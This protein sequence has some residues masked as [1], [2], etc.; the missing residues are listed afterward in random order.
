MTTVL[1]DNVF[2][3]AVKG[4]F[5]DC[6]DM[7]KQSFADQS[8]LLGRRRLVAVN[9][10]NW[11][12]VMAQ[13]VYY[14][15]SA[16]SLGCVDRNIAF[17]VPTGN[18]GDIYA[19]YLAKKMGLPISQ[20][21][22]ATNKNDIL[23]R[24]LNNNDY[25]KQ[26]LEHTLSPSMDIMVSSNFERLLFD[27]HDQDGAAIRDLMADFDANASFSI[28]TERWQRA[29]QLFSSACID[30]AA[31]CDSI[32]NNFRSNEEILDPHTAIGVAA[33]K[34]CKRD[35]EVPMVTLATAHPAKFPEAIKKAGID[36]ELDLPPHMADLM[37]KQERYEIMEH[38]IN[39]LHLKVQQKLNLGNR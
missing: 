35:V 18:F 19:G 38:D 31:T 8:F 23:H 24:F 36:V 5:D 6:Q 13:I 27:L 9:S 25:S 32:A 33:A 10:I 28:A 16:I 2:N 1:A 37:S 20:L 4:N 3:I 39:T 17:S 34:L 26:S 11:A 22:I 29:Q 12:R 30:D 7:L 14:F 21:I 15:H